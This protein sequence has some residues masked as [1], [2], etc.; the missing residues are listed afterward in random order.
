MAIDMKIALFSHKFK[1]PGYSLE[2]YQPGFTNIN[3]IENN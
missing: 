1:K 2:R 3:L